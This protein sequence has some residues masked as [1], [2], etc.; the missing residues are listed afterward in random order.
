[1]ARTAST[2]RIRN[3]KAEVKQHPRPAAARKKALEGH[4]NDSGTPSPSVS[5]ALASDR[6]LLTVEGLGGREGLGDRVRFLRAEGRQG[7]KSGAGAG[8]ETSTG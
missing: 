8:A 5:T 3:N 2:A 6:I 7:R 1:M 4:R